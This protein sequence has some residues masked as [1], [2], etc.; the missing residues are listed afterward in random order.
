MDSK[1]K[2]YLRGLG[3]GIMVTALIL[4][5]TNLNKNN[6]GMTD[7]EVIAR[8]QELGMVSSNSYSLTDAEGDR[9]AAGQ[10]TVN[11]N[12]SNSAGTEIPD[13]DN[14]DTDN[15][16]TS[17]ADNAGTDN[18]DASATDNAGAGNTDAPATDNAGADNT[19]T[20]ATDNAGADN[21][22]ASVTDNAGAGNTDT[23]ATNNSDTD[24]N[25]ADT[26][27][28]TDSS[29]DSTTGEAVSITVTAG[30]GSETLAASLL[31]AGLIEDSKDFN[32]YMVN[33]GYST[34]IRVGTFSIPMGSTYEEICKIVT[35]TKQ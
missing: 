24:N 5:I 8:A 4:A 19:D 7:A 13:A 3:I 22:D 9:E 25:A 20:S 33:N 28:N 32:T 31:R 12:D 26:T 18:T 10:S 21:T 15:T 17:A 30:S 6:K 11:E 35:G 2:I 1:L 23:S 29:S 14:A 34:K 16:D 27:A